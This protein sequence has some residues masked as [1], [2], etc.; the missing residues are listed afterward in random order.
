MN[1]LSLGIVIMSVSLAASPAAEIPFAEDF[2]LAKDRANA[3]KQLIPGTED[4]YYYHCLHLL[5]TEQ[6]EKL[7]AYQKPWLERHGQTQ[8][9]TEIQTRFILLTYERDPKKAL[10]YVRSR[11]GVSF[12][13]QKE[14]VGVAPNLPTSLDPKRIARDTL[15]IDSLRRWGNTDNFE[16]NALDWLAG[17]EL[18]WEKR[19]HL[20]Q[21]LTRPDVPKL[22]ERIVEDLKAP[23]SG[24]FGSLPIH[25]QLTR[26]QL[27]DLLAVRGD[28]L[29]QSAYVNAYLI[30]LHPGADS[31]WKR[32]RDQAKA[33]LESLQTFTARLTPVHNSL[34]AHVLYH[35]L[36]F[37]RAAGV[38]DADRFHAYLKLPRHQSYMAKALLEA[39]E[40][41]RHPAD[42]NADYSAQTLLPRVG[43]D[44]PLVRSYL[45]HFFVKAMNTKDYEPFINDVYLKHLFAETKVENGLGDEEQWAAQLPPE[46]F[47]AIKDRIDIDFAPTNKTDYAVD[48][49]VKLELLVKNVPTL[50][51]KVFEINTGNV[52]RMTQREID[53]DINLDG[54]VANSEK[55]YDYPDPPLRRIT[56]TF[57]FPELNKPGVYVIDF[58][59][60]GKSSRALIRKGQ[61]RS[62]SSLG[63]AGHN[64]RIIDEMN[65]IVKGATAWLGGTEFK[66]DDAGVITIPYSTAPGRHAMVLQ[67]G[68]FASLDFLE[69]KSESYSFTAGF[70]IDRESLLSQ[71]V[72]QLIIRPG[73]YLN[74]RLISTKL[75]EDV[76]LR[77]TSLDFNN[78]PTSMEVPNFK[79]FEDR[80]TTHEIRVPGRLSSLN[81]QIFAKVKALSTGQKIDLVAGET[82][83]LNQIERTDKIEDL[84]FAKFGDEYFLELLGRTGEPKPERP[85][86]FRI[87]HRDFRET[88]NV[89]LKTDA[90]GRIRLGTLPEIE[91]VMATGPEGTSHQWQLGSEYYTYRQTLHAQA[92]DVVRVPYLGTADQPRRS[93]LALFEVR[94]N[95]IRND[96]FESLSLSKGF[97]ELRELKPGDYDL[98]LKTTNEKI[99]IRIVEGPVVEGHILGHTR[100]MELAKLKPLTFQ[101]IRPDGEDIVIQ[102]TDSSPFTRV[103]L[104]ATRYRPEISVFDQ[105][106]QVRASE[107]AG[108]Y[109]GSADSVYLTGRNIG[110]EYRYVLDRKNQKKYPGNMLDR[111]QFLLNPWAIRTT[112]TAEQLAREGQ[113]FGG[114]RAATPPRSEMPAPKKQSPGDPQGITQGFSNFDFLTESATVAVNLIPDKDGMIRVP[115]KGI[116]PHSILRVVAV[117]PLSTLVKTITLPEQQTRFADLRLA[118]GLDPDKHFTQQKQVSVLSKGDIFTLKDITGSRFE[119]FDSTAKVYSLYATLSKDPK[120]A[121]FS[122]LTRWNMMKEDE[123]Q[124]LYSKYS[125]H[126]LNFFIYKKDNP[127]FTKVVKPY[128]ANKKDQTFIDHYLLEHD[129]RDYLQPWNYGRLN[130]VERILLA[131]RINN[132]PQ[133]TI[134]HFED[135]IRLLPPRIDRDRFLFD[136]AVAS[137]TLGD[138]MFQKERGEQYKRELKELQLAMPK[139]A[140]P[141]GNAFN[142]PAAPPPPGASAGGFAGRSAG[143]AEKKSEESA[144]RFRDGKGDANRR[145][146][147]AIEQL[148]KSIEDV[149]KLTDEKRKNSAKDMEFFENERLLERGK[150]IRTFFRNLDPTKE[151]AE[152]N[153]YNL[154]I[155]SQIAEL[156]PVSPFWADYARHTGNG[157]FLSRHLADASRNFTEM[158]FALSVLDLPNE[159]AKH[160]MKFDKGSMT[161]TPASQ[162]IAFHEEVRTADLAQVPLPILVSQNFYRNGD[163]YRNENGEQ[164]DKFVT[165]EF[166]VQV[167]YGCQIVVTNP[168]SSRQ[169]L[170]V[171]TQIPVGA[172]PV[173]N[174]SQTNSVLMDLEPYR[175]ATID[176]FFYFPRSGRF[177][178][179]PMHVGKDDHYIAAATPVSFNVVDSPSK[180]DTTNWDY[181]SQNG[182]NAEVLEF[183]NRE[184]VRALNL[185]KIA[186]RLKDRG[187]FD[188][189]TK[190]LQD[191]HLY[192]ST[193]WSYSILHADLAACREFLQH[194]DGFVNEVGGPI[195]SPLLF[196]DPV[197]RHQYEHLEYKPLVNA[198]AH[199]LGQR[200][201]IVNDRLFGQYSST[202]RQL[203]YRRQ[204]TDADRLALT[205]YLLLQDRI[206]EAIA[207]FDQVDRQK[208]PTQMQYDYCSAY[209]NFYREDVAAA[210]TIS[211]KYANYPVDKWRN[212]F[213]NMTHQLD[214]VAGQANKVT[215]PDKRDQKQDQLAATEPA[216]EFTIEGKSVLL[217]WQNLKT[218]TVN[219]YEM[220]VEL[221]FSRNP[222]VQQSGNQFASIKPNATKVITLP[223]GQSKNTF[224]ID[225]AFVKKNVLVEI[226]AAGQTRTAAY[227]ANAMDVKVTENYGQIK[228]ADVAGLKPLSKVYVKVYAKTA[229]GSVK[230]HKDG[231]TDLRGRFDYVSV[232]TPENQPIQRFSVLILSEDRGATIREVAPPQ[233]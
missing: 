76:R 6:F 53:T 212:L 47:R 103:H 179:F 90:T 77:V 173:N 187:F 125:S 189:V 100:H 96:L 126:E 160:D 85:V 210:R 8:R 199:Q 132:E 74:G 81:V 161:L 180:V 181:I 208:V 151:W 170:T 68:P 5:N 197:I 95:T 1:R 7:D 150:Q 155:Q 128:L 98:Y 231:Y 118:N 219:Y 60:R 31:N 71:R 40:S 176:Y 142:S 110:D 198:R 200:R 129:L 203:T 43:S 214:E 131:Q 134:R 102:L 186:F 163:R 51:V 194:Q 36:V 167:V 46:L 183:L 106:A 63:T 10:E 226:V 154:P 12:N 109:P 227:Y 130:S 11:V 23:H 207:E 228:V 174:G 123:K 177:Q 164:L 19:R 162:A 143:N 221:L 206:E 182:T 138:D 54:L 92:G 89:T 171:L 20:L 44:E 79:L 192:H 121:E 152:N 83:S 191:R 111:P 69:H 113:D 149:D 27:D 147:K 34:K 101:S 146:D 62:I 86:Q 4:Y 22:V 115:R 28:L 119:L 78:I 94:G 17:I 3:L 159:S 75:L 35:R 218:V 88:V 185:D 114:V 158:V 58:I 61:L 29:N 30:R 165:G 16:D 39:E 91:R 178:Q 82:F 93:E 32:N 193:T 117:D 168:T 201:Q 157:H 217:S 140:K 213:I 9:Y 220:D 224:A 137:G 172:I 42:L 145:Q 21:R 196:V 166:L 190:L 72:A 108:V 116:Q 104:L 33:Y 169:K 204:L 156:V 73:L 184:N 49:P 133:K 70:Y 230:F 87:K 205:H 202:V 135:I 120:L 65:A 195:Q 216:Y 13:H 84:F 124:T 148:T 232:S 66:P 139:E 107:L 225:P 50:L 233:R 26:K 18:N 223:D 80:E 153:Y 2:A 97:V 175:T 55:S 112:E 122:F 14:R 56:R 48:E 229:N 45:K 188:A 15:L 38:Y 209:L 105:L 144:A 215:D 211:L 57:E 41:R 141:T 64:I 24:G 59:G 127:F 136:T 25:S 52:Y 222:F 37:D 67:N 99:R